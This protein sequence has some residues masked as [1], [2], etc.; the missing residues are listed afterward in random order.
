MAKEPETYMA[1]NTFLLNF[2][3]K[4]KVNPEKLKI[5][6]SGVKEL[7]KGTLLVKEDFYDETMF[8]RLLKSGGIV[9]AEIQKVDRV[10]PKKKKELTDEI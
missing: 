10:V 3:N 5:S 8:N 6:R 7:M 9:E 1:V 4:N 2:Y